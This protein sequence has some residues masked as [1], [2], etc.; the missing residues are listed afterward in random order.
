MIHHEDPKP[1]KAAALR[2]LNS[3]HVMEKGCLNCDDLENADAN[4][5]AMMLAGFAFENAFKGHLLSTGENLYENGKLREEFR[6]HSYMKWLEDFPLALHGW[7]EEALDKAEFFAKSWARYPAHNIAE[8]E[9]PFETW[10]WEDVGQ[11]RNLVKR[12]INE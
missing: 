12:L 2:L 3:I 5:V 4:F 7:E 11:I 9:R 1:W 8:Q 6:K 10:G